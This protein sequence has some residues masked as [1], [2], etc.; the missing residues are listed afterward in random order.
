MEPLYSET[1]DEPLHLYL[2]CSLCSVDHLHG[3]CNRGAVTWHLPPNIALGALREIY[4][5]I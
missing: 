1:S 4:H 2:L 3:I 5:L